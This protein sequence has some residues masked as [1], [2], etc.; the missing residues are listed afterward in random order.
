[1]G[2][3]GASR[4]S[5]AA[6]QGTSSIAASGPAASAQP[7]AGAAGKPQ[8]AG[9]EASA[10]RNSLRRRCS[11]SGIMSASRRLLEEAS[12]KALSE[13]DGDDAPLRQHVENQGKPFMRYLPQLSEPDLK[14][15]AK[16]LGMSVEARA[17]AFPSPGRCICRPPQSAA[18]RTG[19]SKMPALLRVCGA[20]ARL[21]FALVWHCSRRCTEG[22]QTGRYSLPIRYCQIKSSLGIWFVLWVD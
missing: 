5:A 6:K 15:L 1:M 10:G 20:A 13:V 19:F 2:I 16:R 8:E 3:L 22:W 14:E 11:P 17:R 4:N 9:R 12:R 7:G 18:P 21:V